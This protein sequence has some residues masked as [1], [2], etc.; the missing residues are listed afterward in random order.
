MVLKLLGYENVS[1]YAG[2]YGQWARQQDTP[3]ER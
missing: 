1:T 3:V 2:S